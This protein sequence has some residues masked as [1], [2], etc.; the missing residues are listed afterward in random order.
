MVNQRRLY[1]DDTDGTGQPDRWLNYGEDGELASIQTDTD[2]DGI[3]DAITTP[4]RR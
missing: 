4:T 2:G 3:A 1:A